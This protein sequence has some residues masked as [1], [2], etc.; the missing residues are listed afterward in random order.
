[1]GRYTEAEEEF[2]KHLKN[3]PNDVYA[4][5]RLGMACLNN[6]KIDEAK[7]ILLKS[8]SINEM[9]YVTFLDKVPHFKTKFDAEHFIIKFL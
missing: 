4:L 1:M 8:F 7:K 2:K 5:N 3:N 6:K 9:D